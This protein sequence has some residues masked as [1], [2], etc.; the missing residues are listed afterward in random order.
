MAESST[1]FASS[2]NRDRWFLGRDES[3]MCAYVLHRANQSSGGAETRIE[4]ADFLSRGAFA[5]EHQALLQFIGTL[6]PQTSHTA[7]LL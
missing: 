4:I 2:P 6:V 3:N 5:P 7:A 1:E